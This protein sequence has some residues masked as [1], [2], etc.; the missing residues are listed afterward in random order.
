MN[1]PGPFGRTTVPLCQTVGSATRAPSWGTSLQNLLC[2]SQ[3]STDLPRAA[4]GM[5]S[6]DTEEWV[7][8]KQAP[9]RRVGGGQKQH[10]T[11]DDSW[12]AGTSSSPSSAEASR[13][14]CLFL[15]GGSLEGFPSQALGFWGLGLRAVHRRQSLRDLGEVASLCGSQSSR[16]LNGGTI[17]PSPSYV[18]WAD[19][20]RAASRPGIGAV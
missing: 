12:V 4:G 2:L 8:R 9:G 7:T 19:A 18:R 15:A 13:D 17:A 3:G 16:P 14:P 10:F 1:F 5:C 6:P 11:G 20:E